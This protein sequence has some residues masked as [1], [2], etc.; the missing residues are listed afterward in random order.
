MID[1]LFLKS[2]FKYQ[3]VEVVLSIL[4]LAQNIA[5]DETNNKVSTFYP[6]RLDN[7]TIQMK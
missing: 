6:F 5:C 4:V 3:N 7:F 1:I 2:G